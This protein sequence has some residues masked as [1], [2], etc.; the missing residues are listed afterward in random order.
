MLGYGVSIILGSTDDELLGT[1]LGIAYGIT[2]V[3]GEGSYLGY[4]YGSFNISN[5]GIPVGS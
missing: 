4:P 1:T 3:L 2:L 5:D